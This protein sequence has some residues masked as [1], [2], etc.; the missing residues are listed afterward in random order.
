MKLFGNLSRHLVERPLSCILIAIIITISLIPGLNR[1]ESDFGYRIWFRE[2]EPLLKRYDDFQAKFGNDDLVNIIIHSPDGI[3]DKR[4][5]EI[6]REATE[7][8]WLIPDVISVDSI[9]NYQWTTAD[10]DDIT[11]EDF[12]PEEFDQSILNKKKELAIND[13][14]LPDY[15]INKKATVTNIYAKI[16]PYFKGAPDDK[17]IINKTREMIN[18]IKNRLGKDDK[19]EIYINGSLDI[20]NTFREVSEHDVKTIFPA[21]FILIIIFLTFTFKR[22]LG[23]ILPLIII[24][25][26]TLS[27]FGIAGYLGIKFNNMIAMVPTI[28]IAIAIADSVHVLIT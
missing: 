19:H 1:V 13:K 7:G 20:N 26:T 2:S 17:L 22:L 4:S 24:T 28:I 11:I 23:V 9:T 8:M 12:I 10:G 25:L 21:V 5:I 6:V 27:T 14:T 3:F 18:K 16:R 15:L